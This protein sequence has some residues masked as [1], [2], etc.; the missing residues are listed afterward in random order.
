MNPLIA[1]AWCRPSSNNS[2]RANRFSLE[3]NRCAMKRSENRDRSWSS[4]IMTCRST[5]TTDTS[6][7]ADAVERGRLHVAGVMRAGYC[8]GGRPVDCHDTN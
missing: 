4:R 8:L 3:L 5:R 6:V 7:S 1:A 2:T